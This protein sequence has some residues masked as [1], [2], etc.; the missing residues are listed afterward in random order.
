LGTKASRLVIVGD[1]DFAT[2]Q[3]LEDGPGNPAFLVNAFR[4]MLRDDA[5]LSVMGQATR[6]RR[7]AL[8]AEDHG[9]LRWMVLGLMPLLS[10]LAGA[11]VW[12]SRR[13]R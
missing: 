12:S 6:V 5:R 7:L 2:N 3:L 9:R 11:I 8:T 10:V 1:A 4:W 13:G